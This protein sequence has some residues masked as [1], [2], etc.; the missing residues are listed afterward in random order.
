MMDSEEW[1]RCFR[2]SSARD[3]VAECRSLREHQEAAP[4]MKQAREIALG[5]LDAYEE[6]LRVHYELLRQNASVQ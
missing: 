6:L 5:R 1:L 2:D 4:T 3:Y